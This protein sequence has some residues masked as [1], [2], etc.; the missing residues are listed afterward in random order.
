MIR[1]LFAVALAAGGGGPQPNVRVRVSG[2]APGTVVALEARRLEAGAPVDSVPWS[3]ALPEEGIPL[4]LEP[5]L[6]AIR[7][8]AADRGAAFAAPVWIDADHRPAVVN[9]D[10]PPAAHLEVWVRDENDMPVPGAVVRILPEDTS[11]LP[12]YQG[13]PDPRHSSLAARRCAGFRPVATTHTGE[14]GHASV[15]VLPARTRAAFVVEAEGHAPWTEPL[16]A[17]PGETL[18]REVWLAPAA[19]EA[20]VVVRDA[21]RAPVAGAFALFT[22]PASPVTELRYGTLEEGLRGAGPSD[23]AGRIRIADPPAGAFPVQVSAPGHGIARGSL[24]A[25]GKLLLR[26][27]PPE[28]AWVSVVDSGDGSPVPEATLG[29]SIERVIPAPVLVTRVG[30]GRF[31]LRGPLRGHALHFLARSPR[32]VP[33]AGRVPDPTESSRASPLVVALRRGIGLGV[34]VSVPRDLETRRLRVFGKIRSPAGRPIQMVSTAASLE[35][36]APG[37]VRARLGPLEEGIL[38]LTVRAPWC[39]DGTVRLSVEDG[40]PEPAATVRLQW[41]VKPIALHGVVRDAGGRP[42]S[43]ARVV[44]EIAETRTDGEGRFRADL[45]PGRQKLAVSRMG[46]ATRSVAVELQADD[47][48]RP[49]EVRLEKGARIL[50]WAARRGGSPG[51]TQLIL[52]RKGEADPVATRRGLRASFTDLPAGE[53]TV[54][55]TRGGE[56]HRLGP[57]TLRAGE[58]HV[59]RE[60]GGEG[61][62]GAGGGDVE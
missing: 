17:S 36:V 50:A 35:R 39:E 56:A 21:D 9:V 15:A 14:Q 40:L 57:V 26:L 7:L 13:W 55:L 37:V 5:G 45:P 43:G 4:V 24:R 20:T 33:G 27:P 2:L 58:T 8:E 25:G 49:L 53:Y 6:H 60:E 62:K 48:P 22:D 30:P 38:D 47:P 28:E 29:V 42:V 34:D 11:E 10:F 12:W 54:Y 46:Y 44:W 61:G 16:Y 32:H 59:L 19:P 31:R 41:G 52:Y 3:G 1:V 18:T 51:G 23:A